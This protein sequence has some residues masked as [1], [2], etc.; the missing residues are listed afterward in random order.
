MTTL[1]PETTDL[2]D[3]LV[4]ATAVAQRARL[5]VEAAAGVEASTDLPEPDADFVLVL[6]GVAALARRL[7][8]TLEGWAPPVVLEPQRLEPPRGSL[9]ELLR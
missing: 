1:S 3:G 2:V 6:V 7:E 5:L 9:R 8:A 4:G